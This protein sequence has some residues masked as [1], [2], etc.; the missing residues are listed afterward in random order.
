MHR[1]G[2][3]AKNLVRAA[4]H[5]ALDPTAV[6]GVTQ[7]SDLSEEEFERLY[8]GVKGGSVS[9][10]AAEPRLLD[11]FWSE[12]ELVE[13]DGLPES[14]DWRDQGAVTEVKTQVSIAY[15]VI[16]PHIFLFKESNYL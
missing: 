8:T 1:L 13:V 11:G 2:I 10:S 16:I 5:Q 6:H 3:F 7:F 12:A 15:F 4:Q 14:F 9:V